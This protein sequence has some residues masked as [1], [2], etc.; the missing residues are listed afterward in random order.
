M[1]QTAQLPTE[2]SLA[3][4]P[5]PASARQGCVS[6]GVTPLLPTSAP[7]EAHQL[8]SLE[9]LNALIRAGASHWGE[10]QVHPNDSYANVFI[11]HRQ[12]TVAVKGRLSLKPGRR[13]SRF[14][15]AVVVADGVQRESCEFYRQLQR[16]NDAASFAVLNF[17]LEERTIFLCSSGCFCPVRGPDPDMVGLHVS[18]ILHLLTHHALQV[19]IGVA[20]ARS[21]LIVPL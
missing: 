8:T 2:E 3:E 12:A 9:Q 10:A 6:G 11:C 19:A 1:E 18:E 16:A 14:Q 21:C 13:L 17:C 4:A 5:R 20:G 7:A 15:F